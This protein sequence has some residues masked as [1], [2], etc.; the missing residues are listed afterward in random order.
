V[1][2]EPAEASAVLGSFSDLVARAAA[3]RERLPEIGTTLDGRLLEWP[4]DW[5]PSEVHHRHQSHLYGLYPGAEI[6]PVRTP[7]WAAAARASLER[8]TDGAVNGGWTAAWLVALWARL[9]EPGR[10]IAVIQDYLSRLVSGNLMSRDGDIFQIDANFGITGCVPELLLQSHTDVI[11][12]L[13]ALPPEWPNGSFRGLR[14]RGGLT[15]DAT[16]HNGRLTEA[17]VHATHPGTH[18]IA[19]PSGEQTVSLAAGEQRTL[20]S[21]PAP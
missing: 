3:A 9:F 15:F 10:A 16:W 17:V 7:E 13:P 21:P 5:E 19:L 18:R 6:D 2:S 4:T 12:I 11:R 1:S 14:A 20:T 8:R